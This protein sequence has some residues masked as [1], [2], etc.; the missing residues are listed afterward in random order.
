MAQTDTGVE[1]A[2]GGYAD[3]DP[4][5]Q[6]RSPVIAAAIRDNRGADTDISPYEA[7]GKTI[8]FNPFAADGRPRADL[9]ATR[10]RSGGGWETV[11]NPNQGFWYIGGHKETGGPSR[12]PNVDS[13]E[14]MILESNQP[15]DVDITKES[16]KI[17]HTPV[18]ILKPLLQRL[19]NN[20]PISDAQGNALVEDVGT[21]NFFVGKRLDAEF[22]DRQLLLYR[23]RS[24]GGKKIYTCEG[25]P[26]VKLTDIGESKFGDKK[27][28]D[29]AE[30][31]WSVLPDGYFMVPDG[32]TGELVP[33]I[34]GL[35]VAGEGW[36]SLGGVPVLASEVPVA[37]AGTA[38]K[39]TLAFA[40]P[41]GAADP[42]TI[43]PQYTS[44]D[45]TTWTDAALDVPNAVT[46]DATTTTVKAKSIPSGSKKLR[47]KVVG[48]NGV[49][50]Y[51][52]KSA[53]VTIT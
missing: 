6:Q 51:T 3:I 13:D 10:K 17:T 53:A 42:W 14:L 47:A 16:E 11:T 1:F 30:L 37:T 48:T 24:R 29:A 5:L 9:F 33:G 31:T 2:V 50:A 18:E 19:R 12:K 49:V 40:N 26:L 39:A 41:S 38:G 4:R 43:T 23:A 27:D 36:V 44:D 21:A 32:L 22:V 46:K 35:W 8:K 34:K 52:P 15:T 25:Y 45:G 7:D 28:Q 20:L